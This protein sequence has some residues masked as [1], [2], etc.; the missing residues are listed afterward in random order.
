MTVSIVLMCTVAL[1]VFSGGLGGGVA[2]E[3]NREDDKGEKYNVFLRRLYLYALH[4]RMYD[5]CILYYDAKK[6]RKETAHHSRYTREAL[7]V[8]LLL[9]NTQFTQMK[10]CRFVR[11]RFLSLSSKY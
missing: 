2:A 4:L 7:Y 1:M 11:M 8:Y 10:S 5:A 9:L 6:A 3:D